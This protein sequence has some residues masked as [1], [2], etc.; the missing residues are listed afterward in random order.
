MVGSSQGADSAVADLRPRKELFK[1]QSSTSRKRRGLSKYYVSRSQSFNCIRDLQ[2]NPF[3]QSAVVLAKVQPSWQ[4]PFSSIQEDMCELNSTQ[5]QLDFPSSPRAVSEPASPQAH[6]SLVRHS[7][8][9]S[10]TDDQ[11][12]PMAGAWLSSST[13]GPE[14]HEQLQHQAQVPAALGTVSSVPGCA[15]PI[16]IL[17]SIRCDS[18]GP[19]LSSS[20]SSASSM[21][22][23]DPSMDISGDGCCSLHMQQP[24]DSLCEALRAQA[25]LAARP[26]HTVLLPMV[27]FGSL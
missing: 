6:H 19:S 4:Q 5:Q 22:A 8:P 23:C 25:S 16:A 2:S 13:A 1:S 24:T 27:A 15:G 12:E 21:D 7:W 9:G 18:L 26:K 3:C 11:F 20:D 14:Q 17:P 10:P